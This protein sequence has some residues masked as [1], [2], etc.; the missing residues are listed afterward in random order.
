MCSTTLVVAVD[1]VGGAVADQTA[2]LGNSRPVI[3]TA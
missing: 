1:I 2:D 3:V